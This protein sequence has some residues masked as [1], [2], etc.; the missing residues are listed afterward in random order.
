MDGEEPQ[1]IFRTNDTYKVVIRNKSGSDI[2]GG[3]F[4]GH[5]FFIPVPGL[6]ETMAYGGLKMCY[7]HIPF[8]YMCDLGDGSW[9]GIGKISQQDVPF[10]EVKST[11]TDERVSMTENQKQETQEQQQEKTPKD[12]KKELQELTATLQRLQADFEND[13]KRSEKEPQKDDR[14]IKK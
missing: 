7:P 5:I 11:E 13:K 9:T 4:H 12:P 3:L 6:L 14:L 8:T 2:Y 10:E 1:H